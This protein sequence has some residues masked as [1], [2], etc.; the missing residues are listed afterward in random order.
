MNAYATPLLP[1]GL[2]NIRDLGG[3]PRQGG[4]H[5]APHR[6]LRACAM[7]HIGDADR[8]ALI[9]AGLS[10]VIDLRSAAEIAAVPAAFA[11]QPGVSTLHHPVFSDLDPLASMIAADPDFRLEQRYVRALERAAPRFAAVIAAVADAAPGLVVVHCTAGKDRTGIVAAMLL[12][13]AGV[14]HPAIIADYARTADHG[15][16]LLADLRRRALAAGQPV[17][18]VD[19]TLAAPPQA[20]A[21]TL[22]VLDQVHGGTVAYLR[23]AGLPQDI[24]DRAAARLAA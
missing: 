17:A 15:A 14:P 24:L 21:A 4:G 19:T 10:T 5:T 7:R 11:G 12:D 23:Q 2:H 16:A 22:A 6:V 18:S 8:A 13:L 9:N 1:A 20:M 3:L